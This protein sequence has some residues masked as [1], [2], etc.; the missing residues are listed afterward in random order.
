MFKNLIIN[1]VLKKIPYESYAILQ[2]FEVLVLKK[3]LDRYQY[4]LKEYVTYSF[5][6][7]KGILVL[8][9]FNQK[10]INIITYKKSFDN[11]YIKNDT[12]Y[13]DKDLPNPFNYK[14]F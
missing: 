1:K 13:I 8:R 11:V 7:S 3:W 14:T 9:I 12:V 4:K 10:D 5:E 2:E 6:E